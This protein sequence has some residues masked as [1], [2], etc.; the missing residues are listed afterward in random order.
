MKK[1]KGLMT[2]MSAAR[3]TSTLSS[4]A[5]SRRSE[6]GEVVGVGVLLPVEEVLF[7]ID[8]ERVGEDGGAGVGGRPESDGV[9]AH[10]DGAIVGV[11][12]D[13]IEC[14]ADGHTNGSE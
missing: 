13:V 6:A 3:S 4:V 10:G 1:S 12:G 2:V 8:A 7:R 9:R 14:D 11:A 5:F